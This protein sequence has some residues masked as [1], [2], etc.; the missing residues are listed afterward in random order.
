MEWS[1]EGIEGSNRFIKRIWTTI[2][3]NIGSIEKE[4]SKDPNKL[5]EEELN[6]LIKIN[7]TIEKIS[8]DIDKIQLNTPV[9]AMMELLNS[10][11]KCIDAGCDKELVGYFIYN[12]LILLNPFAPHLSNELWSISKYK[13]ENIN[14][15]W[16]TAD[17][18]ILN[19][20][21]TK[22][23]IQ[24]NG[25]TRGLIEYQNKKLTKEIIFNDAKKDKKINRNLENKEIVKLIYVENKILNIII[26]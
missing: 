14:E 21:K 24:I 10:A 25:K 16:V 20:D 19:L 17:K 12:F 3:K 13:N 9:A 22:M 1:D 18:N 2:A 15:T 4:F 6:F 11:N 5:N 23:V 7:K 8:Y 26:K